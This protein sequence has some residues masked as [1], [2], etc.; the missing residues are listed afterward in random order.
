MRGLAAL[1][2]LAL[3]P[4]IQGCDGERNACVDLAGMTAS[5]ERMRSAVGY[6]DVSPYGDDKQC[7]GCSFFERLPEGDCGHCT[8]LSGPV[9][10][11]GH[12]QSWSRA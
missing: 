2:W 1:P 6:T 4:A 5:E 12:C 7:S 10:A 8:I 9:D 11:G 3:S